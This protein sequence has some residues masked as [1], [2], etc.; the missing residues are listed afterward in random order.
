MK[1]KERERKKKE[2]GSRTVSRDVIEQQLHNTLDLSS[3]VTT[4]ANNDTVTQ[5][6]HAISFNHTCLE[7][8]NSPE[9]PQ[10]VLGSSWLFCVCFV[11]FAF[12]HAACSALLLLDCRLLSVLRSSQS[13]PSLPPP[14]PPPR[15]HSSKGKEDPENKRPTSTAKTRFHVAVQLNPSSFFLSLSLATRPLRVMREKERAR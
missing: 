5:L 13:S 2:L 9:M 1:R 7:I 14:P 3:R 12:E 6:C 11:R 4:T 10:L 8:G 15:P